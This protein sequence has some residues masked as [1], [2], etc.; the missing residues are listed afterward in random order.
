MKKIFS[1]ILGIL[2]LF[3]STLPALAVNDP[4]SVPNNKFGIHIFSEKDLDSARNLVNS[5]GGDWGYVTIVITEA[6]RNHDRWQSVFDQMRRMHLIPIIRLATKADGS[7]WDAPQEAEIDNWVGFLTSLNW[8]TQNRYVIINNEP[9]HATEWGGR[10]DP[11]G[12]ATYLEKI[13]AKLKAASQD[14]FV[15]PGALDA[16]SNNSGN[17]MSE[18]RFLSKMLQTDP[19]VFDSIDG[20][21]SHAYPTSSTNVYDNELKL[22]GKDLP[23]FVTETGWPSDKYS[24]DQISQAL[25]DAYKNVWNDPR[26]V[27][28]TPFILDYTTAPFNIYS[29]EKSDGSFYNFY[30]D[31]QKLPKVAGAP[32]QVESGQIVAA[33]AEPVIFSGVDFVGAIIAKN[34][35][36]SIWSVSNASVGSESDNFYLKGYSFNAIEPMRVGIVLFRAAQSQNQGIYINSLFLKGSKGQR[37]TNSFSI[38]GALL[39]LNKVQIQGLFGKMLSGLHFLGP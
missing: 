32:T 8:V 19:K 23:V 1:V 28:V 22:I 34:T 13:S 24:E 11:A 38:E 9:N 26:V 39:N 4:S 3:V 17:T 29:W 16:A 5:N 27:A 36:Q 25:V 12:Y 18:T 37:I 35:G 31:V 6:E 33:F 14:F 20:W 2:I 21:T 10:V 30:Y 7:T 15:L